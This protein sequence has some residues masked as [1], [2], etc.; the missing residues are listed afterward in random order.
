MKHRR[1]V[2]R[3]TPL[4]A[5]GCRV[6]FLFFF[7]ARYAPIRA[8]SVRIGHN[9]RYRRRTGRF[10]PK[11]KKQKNKR[12]E[13]HRLAEI[14]IKNKKLQN[15]PFGQKPYISVHS[16]HLQLSLPLWSLCSTPRLSGLCSPSPLSHNLTLKSLNSQL[17][18]TLFSV[19]PQV[20][21]IVVFHSSHML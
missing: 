5:R 1:G 21:S 9:H 6:P 17:T 20:L 10:R 16:S 4:P 14:K 12:Y 19:S 2:R 15:A 11:F 3:A 7:S 8:E 13:T 18:H